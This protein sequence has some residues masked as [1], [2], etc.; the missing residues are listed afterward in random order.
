MK[1]ISHILLLLILFTQ[2]SCVTTKNEDNNGFKKTIKSIRENIFKPDS[3]IAKSIKSNRDSLFAVKFDTYEVFTK[4]GKLI[5]NSNY[6]RDGSVYQTTKNEINDNGI[7]IMG[8]KFNSE[9]KVKETWNYIYDDKGN[10]LEV[11]WFDEYGNFDDKQ[12][13]IFDD[14]NNCIEFI[15]YKSD[16]SI[17]YRNTYLYDGKGNIK[18]LIKYESNG[19]LRYRRTYKYDANRNETE[20]ILY[21]HDGTVTKFVSEYDEKNNI[22][23]N[24]WF[25][26]KGEQT[27]L[28]SFE[29]VYDK[30][31][32]WTTKK[33]S[34]NGVLGMVWERKIEYY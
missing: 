22:T 18:E 17:S 23:E 31:G 12:V 27:H 15:R 1:K 2:L 30:Y 34:S 5:E 10:L 16:E 8:T 13:S 33:R 20:Q 11:D 26:E 6:E 14:N 24:Y 19:S 7:F 28:T 21:K 9:G 3:P 29:Y 25:N 4:N 32:Y